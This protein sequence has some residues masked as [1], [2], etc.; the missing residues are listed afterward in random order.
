MSVQVT[1]VHGGVSSFKVHGEIIAWEVPERLKIS[2]DVLRDG[3]SAA[4]LPTD[5]ARDRK[6]KGAFLRVVRDLQRKRLV[7]RVQE[8]A[9]NMSFQ[10]TKESKVIEG[11]ADTA[12]TKLQYSYEAILNLHKP[13]GVVTC[14]EF[15]RMAET[16]TALISEKIAERNSTDVSHILFALFGSSTDIFPLRNAGGAYFV[17]ERFSDFVTKVAKFL[18]VVPGSFLRRYV[19]PAGVSPDS[20][21]AVKGAVSSGLNFFIR[22]H[23][24]AIE[25]FGDSS[26]RKTVEGYAR[27]INT[28]RAKIARYAE[29]LGEERERLETALEEA[30]EALRSKIDNLFAEPAVS[31]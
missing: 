6:P 21:E 20:D 22:E 7:R 14:A 11:D 17:P 31:V 28:T 27:E 19:V 5:V 15:P 30:R 26:R 4:G 23:F 25:E 29:Y 12:N 3:L 8:D 10:L 1:A 2:V 9:T 18:E 13:T 16:L 24:K